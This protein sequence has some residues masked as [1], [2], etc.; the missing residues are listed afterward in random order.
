MKTS[1]T[2]P[3]I[4]KAM[5]FAFAICLAL[6]VMVTPARAAADTSQTIETVDIVPQP[7]SFDY[8]DHNVSRAE[9]DQMVYEKDVEI[10]TR[11]GTILRANVFRPAV[12]GERY[13]A[14]IAL[15]PY[16]KDHRLGEA[17]V[18]EIEQAG[19][20]LTHEL[21]NPDF[22][23]ARGY[24]VVWVDTR[25]MGTSTGK[26]NLF[27]D[28]EALDYYDAIEWVAQQSWSDGG[29]ASTG[30]SYMAIVQWSMGSTQPP[31]LTAMIPWEGADDNYRTTHH[32]GIASTGF[33]GGWWGGVNGRQPDHPE[34]LTGEERFEPWGTTA[35]GTDLD[36]PFF[37]DHTGDHSRITVPILS[38]DESA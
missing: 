5:L 27:S 15:T 37:D 30:I 3:G 18:A 4:T 2:L 29:V 20:Y 6:G 35:L 13:P 21:P 26:A 7:S 9:Y 36:G 11:D 25:G 28:Q 19:N 1:K 38:H 17:A 31:H 8:S 33:I 22:W 10:V 34:G 12:E 23:A 24:A 16:V 14:L 32:G